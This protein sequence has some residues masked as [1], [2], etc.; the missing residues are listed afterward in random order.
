MN[1]KHSGLRMNS[2]SP[3]SEEHFSEVSSCPGS[4]SPAPLSHVNSPSR[5]S[6]TFNF[7]GENDFNFNNGDIDNN[8]PLSPPQD[9]ASTSTS[10]EYH[11]YINGKIIYDYP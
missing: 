9:A 2:P 6:D 11:P 3:Q 8:P 5:N 1:A 10:T 4:L 7:G